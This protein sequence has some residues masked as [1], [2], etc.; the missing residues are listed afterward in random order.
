MC[1]GRSLH[2]EDWLKLGLG[3]GAAG[4][5]AQEVCDH[6]ELALRVHGLTH[7]DRV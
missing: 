5:G 4:I 2:K 7:R 6:A 1:G 3:L